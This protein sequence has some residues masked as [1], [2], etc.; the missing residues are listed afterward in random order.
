MWVGGLITMFGKRSG[1]GKGKC[2]NNR[3]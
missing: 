2:V 1:D 3:I